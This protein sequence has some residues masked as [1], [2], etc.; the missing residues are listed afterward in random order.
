VVGGVNYGVS[1]VLVDVIHGMK[2]KFHY[3]ILVADR[4]EAGR[5][6]VTDLL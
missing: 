4:C 6:P 1:D 3:A 2:V 5:R